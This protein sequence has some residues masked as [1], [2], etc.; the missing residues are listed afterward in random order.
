MIKKLIPVFAAALA[1]FIAGVVV[2]KP[3]DRICAKC[4][5]CCDNEDESE[6]EDSELEDVVIEENEDTEDA[7]AEAEA[8]A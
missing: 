5:G 1:G 4:D 6:D 2:G 7:A 3:H 8:E